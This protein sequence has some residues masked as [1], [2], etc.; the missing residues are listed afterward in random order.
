M[1]KRFTNLLGDSN[2][3]VIKDLQQFVDKI[4]ELEPNF[5]ALTDQELRDKTTE[6][7]SRL[8]QGETLEDLLIEAFATVRE[9]SVRSI[10]LRHFDVQLLGGVALHQGRIAVMKTGE[11]KTLVA[12]L[13]AYLNALSGNGVHV[14]TVNDYL[15]RRDA[16]WM[17]TIYSTLGLS[18]GA[19]QNQGALMY[20][21]DKPD[22]IG[23]DHM[24]SA[25]RHDACRADK[26]YGTNNEFGFDYLRDNMKFER[27][28]TT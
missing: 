14:V 21:T 25:A 1:L 19:L 18:I 23:E 20:S 9:A 13:P 15:A 11:G 6:F 17:G 5:Q 4:N 8:K 28:S 26:T 7:R 22:D 10:G 2:E 27:W 12:T 24:V 16:N 3:R